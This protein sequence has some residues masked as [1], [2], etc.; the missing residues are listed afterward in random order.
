MRQANATP[1]PSETPQ[2]T[3][4]PAAEPSAWL[5]SF[6]DQG[7]RVYDTATGTRTD[8]DL[9]PLWDPHADLR[10]IPGSG[11]L[12]VRAAEDQVD[13]SDVAL[14]IL[15]LPEGD[16]IRRIPLLSQDVSEWI[17]RTDDTFLPDYEL[18][19]VIGAVTGRWFRARWS[20]DGTALAFSATQ[21]DT[22]TDVYLY[23][24]LRD[25]VRRLTDA[26]DQEVVLGWSPDGEW[27]LYAEAWGL[28]DDEGTYFPQVIA[29]ASI[30]SGEVRELFEPVSGVRLEVVGWLSDTEVVLGGV[31]DIFHQRT[32]LVLLDLDRRQAS[33]L[34]DGMYYWVDLDP[35]SG[36]L[37]ISWHDD[38]YLGDLGDGV[39]V[40][41]PGQAPSPVAAPWREAFWGQVRWYPQ[42]ERFIAASDAD[43]LAFTVDGEPA[44]AFENEGCLPAASPDGRWLAF[45]VCTEGEVMVQSPGLRIYTPDGRKVRELEP[46]YV[47]AVTWAPGSTRL[48]YLRE[49]GS[50]LALVQAEVPG[51][52]Q[53][54]MEAGARSALALIQP[55]QAQKAMVGML[56]TEAPNPTPI[57]EASPSP[58][59]QVALNP[60]GPWLVGMT[61]SGPVAMNPDGTGLTQLFAEAV[62]EDQATWLTSDISSAGWIAAVVEGTEARPRTLLVGRPGRGVVRQIPI[63]SPELQADIDLPDEDGWARRWTQDVYLAFDDWMDTLKWSPDGRTLAYVAAV[64]GPSADI[65]VYDTVSNQIRRLTDGP[66]QPRM[67]G[68]SPD[69]RWLLHLEIT[70]IN[71]GDGIWWDTLG[72]WAAAADGSQARK[73]PGVERRFVLMAWTSPTQFLAVYYENGPRPPAQID[74]IDLS[75]GPVATLYSGE[76]YDWSSD[77]ATGTIA[78]PAEGE[79]ERGD[80]SPHIDLYL[81]SPGRSTPRLVGT[82][83]ASLELTDGPVWSP[84]L[85]A[86]LV[87]AR[88]DQVVLISTEGEIVRRI[89][90][91]CSL[92]NP[93]PDGRWLALRPCSSTAFG[94]ELRSEADGSVHQLHLGDFNDFFWTPDSSGTDYFQGEYPEAERL[95]FAAVPD[96][97]PRLIHP[98]SGLRSWDETVRWVWGP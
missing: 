70:D 62:Q 38:P 28:G 53:R 3:S 97:E 96:G 7:I 95:M 63:L 40:L 27:V 14:A 2:P 72:L 11:L 22:G 25:E 55:A 39:A 57:A 98:D 43:T 36:A 91:A 94:L 58:T 37:A 29:A 74:L 76:V 45:G 8:P 88:G 10:D 75:R 54:I 69:G 19:E 16:V 15:R 83:D 61:E 41:N 59:P 35:R 82:S 93:S 64:E 56:S 66:N 89:E 92:P 85:N 77:P 1:Q 12:A 23:D 4:T 86:F 24:V 65:Y 78:F 80:E 67:L 5:L 49:D 50:G 18:E 79:R 6:D 52:Q 30:V 34:Y 48:Y 71:L 90:G 13:G 20:P 81:L 60:G 87:R 9:P 21:D 17:R 68:W 51:G 31:D 42:L 47:E 84:E 26:A 32:D 33:T 73:V 46:G 44:E